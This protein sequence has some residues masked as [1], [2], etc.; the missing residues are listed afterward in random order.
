MCEECDGWQTRTFPVPPSQPVAAVA[1]HTDV[2]TLIRRR[3]TERH[4][5]LYPVAVRVHQARR[6]GRHQRNAG[7]RGHAFWR[8]AHRLPRDDIAG[9]LQSVVL[10]GWFSMGVPRLLERRSLREPARAIRI[11]RRQSLCA[12]RASQPLSRPLATNR[13]TTISASNGNDAQC[14]PSD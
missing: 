5:W 6:H 13:P 12:G 3:L 9:C 8:Q 11:D 1:H 14:C 7:G 2:R 4:P 10:V